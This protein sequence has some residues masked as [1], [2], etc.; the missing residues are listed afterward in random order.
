MKV[1]FVGGS[2]IVCVLS[3]AILVYYNMFFLVS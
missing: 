1:I 2:F 3:F